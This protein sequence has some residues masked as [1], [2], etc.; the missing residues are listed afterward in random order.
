MK[1][2]IITLCLPLLSALLC[3]LGANSESA[4][5]RSL[6]GQTA[7]AQDWKSAISGLVSSVTGSNATLTAADLVGTWNYKGS[8]CEFE[9]DNLLQKA[10]GSLAASRVAGKMD[11]Y[12]AKVGIKA[13]ACSFTFNSDGT[14]TTV[15]NKRSYNG[16]YTFDEK[17]AQIVVSSTTGLAKLTAT[18]KKDGGQLKLL[19]NADKLLQLA[20]FIGKKSTNT[21]IK[22]ISALLGSYDGMQI[23]MK[24]EK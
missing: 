7:A 4:L 16:K 21:S 13:G 18:V 24:L 17:T 22:S 20:E 6:A 12:L 15:V 9:S 8:T 2:T 19:F 3:S 5:L 10:G 11:T 23:G 1:K 14:C